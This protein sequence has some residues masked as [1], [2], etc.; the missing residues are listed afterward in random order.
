M[1][2]QTVKRINI[3]LTEEDI[4]NLEW[5]KDNVCW[6]YGNPTTS[7]YIRQAIETYAQVM[8]ERK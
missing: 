8:G 3:N 4:K 7:D 1:K 2:K 5:I 6:L